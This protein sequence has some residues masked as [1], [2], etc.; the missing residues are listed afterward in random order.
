MV[1]SYCREISRVA[2]GKRK[3]SIPSLC[4]LLSNQSQD[5][6]V[7]SWD[8]EFFRDSRFTLLFSF[9]FASDSF[10][11][12]SI[13]F[14]VSDSKISNEQF[15]EIRF[16]KKETRLESLFE[17]FVGRCYGN[18]SCFRSISRCSR[19]T[20]DYNMKLYTYASSRLTLRNPI[21]SRRITGYP[22][23]IHGYQ[24]RREERY[25]K[26]LTLGGNFRWNEI[27]IPFSPSN[28]LNYY[29][30]DLSRKFENN[31]FSFPRGNVYLKF[32]NRT[33]QASINAH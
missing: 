26:S 30:S 24:S 6:C 10:W 14:A 15:F 1:D 4:F 20:L 27:Y 19:L 18:L 32:F 28:A 17:K 25:I 7:K 31:H 11:G 12:S 22:R 21:L 23:D 8:A 13:C 9:A 33:R 2:A 29:P 16:E 5:T 3:N